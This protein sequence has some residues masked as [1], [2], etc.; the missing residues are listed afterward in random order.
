[1]SHFEISDN[2]IN[3]SQKVNKHDIF[4]MYDVF[5]EEISGKNLREIQS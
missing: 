3:D 5:Q 4:I 1:M 2:K